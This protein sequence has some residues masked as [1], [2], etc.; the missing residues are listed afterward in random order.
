MK[1]EWVDELPAIDRG[2]A[3]GKYQ[4]FFDALRERPGQWAIMPVE[5]PRSST[6]AQIRRGTYRGSAPGEFEASHRGGCTYV[7]YVG[8]LEGV[9]PPGHNP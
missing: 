3:R 4:E 5:T 6:A 2:R 9:L 7:R 1:I 8:G